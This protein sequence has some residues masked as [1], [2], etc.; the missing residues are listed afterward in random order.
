[1]IGTYF[2]VLGALILYNLVLF[3]SIRDRT[4]IFFSGSVAFFGLT[5]AALDGYGFQYLWPTQVWWRTAACR[6]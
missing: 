1:M 3:L 5:A 2:G 4:Y 6:S